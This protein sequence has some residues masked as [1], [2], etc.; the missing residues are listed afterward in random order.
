MSSTDKTR[1]AETGWLQAWARAMETGKKTAIPA[2]ES[3]KKRT[4]N[5]FQ[6]IFMGFTGVF[7]KKEPLSMPKLVF[8]ALFTMKM[9]PLKSG[10]ISCKR[11]QL[12]CNSI[13]NKGKN[14]FSN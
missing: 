1:L 13:E 12:R 2:K 4:F 9:V 11:I 7:F 10:Q 6:D 3:G 14:S 8:Y 5:L